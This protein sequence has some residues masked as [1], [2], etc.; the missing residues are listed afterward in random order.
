MIASLQQFCLPAYNKD[1]ISSLVIME[2]HSDDRS[3]KCI[4]KNIKNGQAADKFCKDVIG[5]LQSNDNQMNE[6]LACIKNYCFI[7]VT[8]II[9]GK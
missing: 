9:I 8:V 2:I 6:T 7:E 5:K 1:E 3:L 4:I